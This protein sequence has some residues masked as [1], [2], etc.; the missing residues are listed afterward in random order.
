M[1]QIAKTLGLIGGIGGTALSAIIIFV[2]WIRQ[3]F[4]RARFGERLATGISIWSL[5]LLVFAVVGI[6]GAALVVTKPK[7]GGILAV[8]VSSL[9]AG[10][11]GGVDLVEA[12][13]AI[14]LLASGIQGMFSLPAKEVGAHS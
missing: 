1:K 9:V 5:F 4:G 2:I 14:L 11:F 13:F 3:V 8:T 10:H 6:V 12:I 7:P